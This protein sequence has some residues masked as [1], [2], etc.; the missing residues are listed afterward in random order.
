MTR[1]PPRSPL[2]PYPP[3]SRSAPCPRPQGAAPRRAQDRQPPCHRGRARARC[4]SALRREAARSI[5][6]LVLLPAVVLAVVVLGHGRDTPDAGDQVG[7]GRAEL[8]LKRAGDLSAV[9]RCDGL[10][11]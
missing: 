6:P 7:D 2:S 4:D 3:L 9:D 8:L 1:R 10:L 5:V 11:L